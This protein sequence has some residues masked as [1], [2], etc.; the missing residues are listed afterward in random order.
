VRVLLLRLKLRRRLCVGRGVRLAKG[1]RIEI[2]PGARV[3]LEPGCRL[4]ARTR[5][6]ARGGTLKVGRE[7]VLGERCIVV[8]HAGI[9][10]G[11]GCRLGDW[12]TITDF[13]PITDSVEN[14]LRTQGVRAAPIRLAPG[15]IVDHGANLLAGVAVGDH[16]RVG[17]HAIVARD[18]PDGGRADG[19]SARMTA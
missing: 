3:E 16:A 19:A 18:V 11:E 15:A 9:D 17:P 6:I 1:V 13:E 8:A 14:P 10:V 12:V 2:D 7:A 5:L 4:G